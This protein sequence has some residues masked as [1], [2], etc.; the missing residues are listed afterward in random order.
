MARSMV[1]A[2][3]AASRDSGSLVNASVS[4]SVA[5]AASTTALISD[6][7]PDCDIAITTEPASMG[8]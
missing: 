1:W 2:A 7:A 6:P 3:V 5:L 8:F 4:A